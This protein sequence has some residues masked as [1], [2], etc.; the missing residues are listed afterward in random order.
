MVTLSLPLDRWSPQDVLDR[1]ATSLAEAR[2]HGDNEVKIDLGGCTA[3]YSPRRTLLDGEARAVVQGLSDLGVVVKDLELYWDENSTFFLESFRQ[4]RHLDVA[5][6]IHEP[7][8]VVIPTA[9]ALTV[10][11]LHLRDVS[12]ISFP[13]PFLALTTLLLSS[14][15]LQTE[16]SWSA[17]LSACPS[18][19][20]LGISYCKPS[21][22]H[23]AFTDAHLPPTLEHI[24]HDGGHELWRDGCLFLQDPPHTVKSLTVTQ[25]EHLQ[26]RRRVLGGLSCSCARKG[27]QFHIVLTGQRR[28]RAFTLEKWAEGV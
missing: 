26:V 27:I 12:L 1:C 16:S 9:C 23:D 25:P 28:L 17:L 22:P 6:S 2:A 8:S 24:C 15:T 18:L 11:Y 4:F 21:P 20:I 14:V 10:Q 19:H 5:C 13:H 3:P 7:Q